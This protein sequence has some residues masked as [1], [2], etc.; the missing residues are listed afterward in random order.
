MVFVTGGSWQGKREWA[1]K[2]FPKLTN[3]VDGE[4]AEFS[5]FVQAQRIDRLHLWIRRKM[6]EGGSLDGYVD[7]LLQQNP[8]VVILMDEVGSGV[9]PV[10]KE[11]RAYREKVGRIG[12]EIAEKAQSVYRVIC[13]IGT[14]IK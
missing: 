1:N 10:D 4:T 9:V 11:E 14:E 13:G 5:D 8:D 6:K 12:C 3:I 2:T 7:R